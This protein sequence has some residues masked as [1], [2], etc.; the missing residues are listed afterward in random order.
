M[1]LT[2]TYKQLVWKL[3]GMLPKGYRRIG[4]VADTY[5]EVSIKYCERVDRATSVC[6]M[7]NY[8]GCSDFTKLTKCCENKTP[9]SFHMRGFEQL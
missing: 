2:E 5:K 7:N 8:S 6:L 4:M 3:L 9:S 1:Y